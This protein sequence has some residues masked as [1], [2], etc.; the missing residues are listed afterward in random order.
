VLDNQGLAAIN[1]ALLVKRGPEASD[2]DGIMSRRFALLLPC[3]ALALH[4]LIVGLCTVMA[5][6]S[7]HDPLATIFFLPLFV[8]DLPWVFVLDSANSSLAG[9]L[10]S[11]TGDRSAAEN[12]LA[13]AIGLAILGPLHWIFLAWLTGCWLDRYRSRAVRADRSNTRF[14]GG[15]RM[16]ERLRIAK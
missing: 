15:V 16:R 1:G 13:P 3:Y 14:A 8:A 7:R 6:Q 5:W 9:L 12:V 11:I 10:E 4:T 2:A